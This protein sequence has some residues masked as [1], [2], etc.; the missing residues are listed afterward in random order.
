MTK[1]LAFLALHGRFLRSKTRDGDKIGG[2]F[3]DVHEPGAI[4]GLYRDNGKENGNYRDY[5]GLYKQ[6]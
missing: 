4:Y 6:G 2:A 3:A 5:I 1:A